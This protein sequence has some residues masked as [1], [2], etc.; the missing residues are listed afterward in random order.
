[1]PDSATTGTVPC[2]SCSARVRGRFCATCGTLA[3]EA[4]CHACGALLAPGDKFCGECGAT[5]GAAAG[6]AVGPLDGAV[7]LPREEWRPSTAWKVGVGT[8]AALL[9]VTLYLRF[10]SGRP[11]SAQPVASS[12]AASGAPAGGASLGGP[13]AGVLSMPPQQQADALF[14]RVMRLSEEGKRDSV[15]FF[16]PMALSVYERLQP[17][18]LDQRFDL[19]TVALAAGMHDAASAQADTI[20]QKDPDH[21][22]GLA[23]M[24]R[25]GRATGSAGDA[26]RADAH[27]RRVAQAQL[28]LSQ[29]KPEYQRHR[30]DIETEL[31][32]L[33]G[34]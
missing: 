15:Q 2:P 13:S 22:L 25:A 28:Q 34:M 17:L 1:M 26:A 18:D 7:P 6:A 8:L 14:D 23:L 9:V 19:G 16:A 4:P 24:S 32:R 30:L 12:L 10:A 21:L 11:P 20:L 29:Q 27:F 31:K 3:R 5:A 33:A